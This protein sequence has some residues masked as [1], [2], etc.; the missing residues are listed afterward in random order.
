MK[1]QITYRTPNLSKS[2]LVMAV[3]NNDLEKV[4]LMNQQSLRN[5]YIPIGRALLHYAK[6]VEMVALLIAMGAETDAIDNYGNTAL[7]YAFL[8]GR[9]DIAIFLVEEAA[10]SIYF[11][12]HQFQ[13]NNRVAPIIAQLR[14][15]GYHGVI[16]AINNRFDTINANSG[17]SANC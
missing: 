13:L 4:R 12:N 15:D 9:M 7:Y 6:N 16:N 17:L 11:L 10:A 8:E 2:D 5:H 3:V 1:A 14:Y